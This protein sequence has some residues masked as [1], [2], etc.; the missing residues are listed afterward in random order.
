MSELQYTSV[1]PASRDQVILSVN[2]K[3]GRRSSKARVQRL[4][5]ALTELGLKVE[6]MTDLVAVAER[7]NSLHEAG[8]LRALVGVGGDGTAAELTNRTRPGVPI[9]LL[10]SGTANLLAKHFKYSFCPEKFAKMIAAGKVAVLDAARANGRLFLAMVGCGFDAEVVQQVHTARMQNPK[11]AHI[12]YFSYTKPILRAIGSYT[13]PLVNVQPLDDAGEPAGEAKQ[14]HWAFLCN[15]PKYGWGVPVAPQ[16]KLDD[17]LMNLCLWR[18]GSLF[19]GLYLTAVAQMGVHGCCR[20]CTVQ[21][22]TRY[23]FTPANP[24]HQIPYQL[25]GDPGGLLP[26]EITVEPGRLTLVVR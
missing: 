2:P 22:G 1:L 15:I 24:E 11:G 8:K 12:N 4:E 9:S 6:T 19:Q 7:A 18:G 20:R 10:A 21:T 16:A 26:L 23:R 17:G 14:S 5:K 3:A 25:D 13:W